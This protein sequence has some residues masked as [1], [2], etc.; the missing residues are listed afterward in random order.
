MP[1]KELTDARYVRGQKRS[2]RWTHAFGV[3]CHMKVDVTY[4]SQQLK[5]FGHAIGSLRTEINRARTTVLDR[6][7]QGYMSKPASYIG[8]VNIVTLGIQIASCN[9]ARPAFS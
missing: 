2:I 6:T 9:V 7:T 3:C 1:L 4:L 8:D 5:E